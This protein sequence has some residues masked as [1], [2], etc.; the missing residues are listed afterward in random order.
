M[1]PV[2]TKPLPPEKDCPDVEDCI[3]E[4]SEIGH[5]C[6]FG[7]V[8]GTCVVYR[9]L[10][11]KNG[12]LLGTCRIRT[13][14]GDFPCTA[15]ICDAYVPRAGA[16]DA[17]GR[18]TQSS[19]PIALQIARKASVLPVAQRREPR[20]VAPI[21]R[22][23]ER[24]VSQAPVPVPAR[25]RTPDGPVGELEMTREE[26]KAL[27]RE[28]M[29]EERGGGLAPLAPK[30]EGGTAVLKP[31]DAALQPK[32]IP[33]ES[34]F[35]K[36]VMIRDRLRVLEQKINGNGKLTDAEKVDMQAYITGCYGSLTTFNVLFRDK[37]D[38]FVGASGKE[39]G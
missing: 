1:D 13:D 20:A 38:G 21:I 24:D 7:P 19:M 22:G 30:W 36:V 10:E 3:S 9:V 5:V 23:R 31:Q 8:C 17:K 26:L 4:P 35:H 12:L 16:P 34:L 18:P 37:D 28:A 27:I 25:D 32:E 29:D 33:L 2:V 14:R 15:P 11:T 6:T 39:K